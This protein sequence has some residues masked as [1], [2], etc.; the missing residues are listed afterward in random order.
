MNHLI[1]VFCV[2]LT[3][4]SYVVFRRVY[5]RFPNP[6]CN[7]VVLGAAAVIAVLLACGLTYEDYLPAQK[8]STFLLGPATIALAV[9]LYRNRFLLRVYGLAIFLGVGAGVCVSMATSGI[10]AV[11]AGLPRNVVISLIPK[12]VTIPFAVD[13]CRIYGGEPALTTAFVVTNGTLG[14]S[15]GL[16]TLSKSGIFDPVARGLSMGTISHGQGTA[17]CFLEGEKQGAMSGL[18]MT[19]AGCFTAGLAPLIMPFFVG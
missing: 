13:I 14:A 7:V 15:F 1:T 18:A 12:G 16:W 11:W 2:V 19:L 9:P 17:I 8:V 10:L 4:V 5:A 3:L 6:L